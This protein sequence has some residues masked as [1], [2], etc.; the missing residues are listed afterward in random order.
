MTL[1]EETIRIL[2][3]TLIDDLSLLDL[4][5]SSHNPNYGTWSGESL[6]NIEVALNKA[7]KSIP[8]Q[9]L[10]KEYNELADQ[11]DCDHIEDWDYKTH[12]MELEMFIDEICYMIKDLKKT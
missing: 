5:Y 11:Y 7:A 3:N 8:K 2:K 4:A 6:N 10:I 12:Q 1:I 9:Q